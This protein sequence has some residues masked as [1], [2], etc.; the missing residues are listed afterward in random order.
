MEHAA[1]GRLHKARTDGAAGGRDRLDGAEGETRGAVCG[2]T[3]R[4][5]EKIMREQQQQQQQQ[6]FHHQHNRQ[7]QQQQQQQD[8]A[9]RERELREKET[10]EQELREHEMREQEMRE[11]AMREQEMREQE[12]REQEMREQAMREQ[13]MREQAMREQEIRHFH[14]QQQ[15]FYGTSELPPPTHP[16]EQHQQHQHQHQHQHQQQH[17]Q[18]QG[19]GV[20]P[21]PSAPYQ[22]YKQ[23]DQ[24][25]APPNNQPFLS[26]QRPDAPQ[27]HMRQQHYHQSGAGAYRDAQEEPR[28]YED[29]A[30]LLDGLGRPVY[31]Y[32]RDPGGGGREAYQGA[33]WAEQSSAQYARENGGGGHGGAWRGQVCAHLHRKQF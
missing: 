16:H 8:E 18:Q 12:M 23:S 33:G 31:D 22:P 13:E 21:P 32:P 11:Q 1:A 4:M 10:R 20:Q 14:Q 28:H 7:Q 6:D 15:Q 25:P 5:L 3:D 26:G 2:E 19:Y 9:A 17:Q 24:V 29:P 27:L 30:P